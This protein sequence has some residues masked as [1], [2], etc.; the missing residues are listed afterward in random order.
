MNFLNNA[1]VILYSDGYVD[2]IAIEPGIKDHA[3]YYKK[4]A[5]LSE[6]FREL[7][8]NCSFDCGIH[9]HVDKILAENQA[10]VFQNWNVREVSKCLQE[11][12][13]FQ[14]LPDFAIYF[15][16]QLGSLKQLEIFESM[17]ENY[18]IIQLTYFKYVDSNIGFV[19]T[20]SHQDLLDEINEFKSDY[21]ERRN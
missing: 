9:Y 15:S 10:I 11:G 3:M 16:K 1:I 14:E 12:N 8:G 19:D 20:Y 6:R 17:V 2:S 4:L 21:I 5:L 7:C 18:P 13:K